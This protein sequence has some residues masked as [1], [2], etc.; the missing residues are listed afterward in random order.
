[1]FN[2]WFNF[3]F[4]TR[5]EFKIIKTVSDI[6]AN[7]CIMFYIDGY[8]KYLIKKYTKKNE[9]FY[10]VMRENQYEKGHNIE[11]INQR[12]TKYNIKPERIQNY[13]S[14]YTVFLYKVFGDEKPIDNNNRVN[15]N[16]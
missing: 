14:K 2:I 8:S 6:P 4:I 5:F 16:I 3:D 9:I 7:D 1:M 11:E 10:Q 15:T 12:L 13:L